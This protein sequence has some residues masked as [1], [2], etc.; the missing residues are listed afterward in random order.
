MAVTTT[1]E[2]AEAI[3]KKVSTTLTT[4]LQQASVALPTINDRSNEVMPG[5]D[6]LDIILFNELSSQPVDESTGVSASTIDPSANQLDLDKHES[7]AWAISQ[8][9]SLQSKVN[10]VSQAVS[11]GAVRMA[12]DID[13]YIFSL[14]DAG[15]STAAPDHRLQLT[16]N[17]LEDISN[18]KKL[19]DEAN[20]SRLDR[21]I[22]AS[23][24]FVKLLLDDNTIV[25]AD[26]F[27][28]SSARENGFVT[29][30][31]GFTI[32]ESSSPS[33][34]DGG[35]QAY[36]RE[37]V[38]F[39]RQMAISFSS[40]YKTLLHRTEYAMTHLYGAKFLADGVRAVVYDS[41][42]A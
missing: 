5:M 25:N 12:A 10:A 6:R 17:P 31:H 36:H 22:A 34:I 28:N 1:T 2:M 35:F 30:I 29:R 16:A 9:S 24:A 27:G 14:I 19:L 32:V 20:V 33:I 40:E 41:D 3:E 18:A 23:P 42:G 8:K 11:Q 15:V 38:A 7:I 4:V 21:Y 39:A 26:Q 37:S 13:D